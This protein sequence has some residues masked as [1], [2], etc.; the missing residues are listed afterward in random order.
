MTYAPT[1]YDNLKVTRDAPEE[2]I[3]AAYKALMQIYH[4]ENFLDREEEAVNAITIIKTSFDVLL[5]PASRAEYDKRLKEQR[6][7]RI[8]A[9]NKI[10]KLAEEN[11]NLQKDALNV[12]AITDGQKSEIKFRYNP[13]FNSW[14]DYKFNCAIAGLMLLIVFFLLAGSPFV[15]GINFRLWPESTNNPVMSQ[16]DTEIPAK[17]SI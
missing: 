7:V 14:R 10:I 3:R 17:G 4:P 1:H 16:K 11:A 2:V 8:R 5:D 12:E 6:R 15:Q 9:A 13:I